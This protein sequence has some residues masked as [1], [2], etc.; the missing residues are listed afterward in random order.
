MSVIVLGIASTMWGTVI[1]DFEGG[2]MDNWVAGDANNPSVL[3]NSTT[4]A[5]LG[6]GSLAVKLGGGGY[7]CL[8]W[9]APTVPE[10][11]AGVKLQFDLTMIQSEWTQNN[12]T[13]VADKIAL[14]SN[15][16]SGYQEY[17]NLAVAKDR[18][19]GDPVPL[20][21]GPWGPDALKTYTLDISDYDL[22]DANWFQIGISIQQNPTE[23][24]GYFYIDNVKMFGV[25]MAY[26]PQ[27]ADGSKDVPIDTNISWKPGAYANKH[28]VYFGTNF[29]DVNDA[30]RTTPRG[31][32]VRP[33]QDA[34][35]YDPPGLLQSGKIYY[36]RI[37]EVNGPTTWRGDVWR[38]STPYALQGYV[39]GNWENSM[40]G[41][42]IWSRTRATSSYS[43]TGA[44][45][46]NKTLKLS[47]PQGW[48]F[49]LQL[50]LNAAQLEALKANDLFALDV[51]WVKSEWEGRS[52]SNVDT[53]A[54]NS[55]GFNWQWKQINPPISDTSNPSSPGQWNPSE[56]GDVDTRTITWDYSG[57]PVDDIPAG[58]GTQLIIATG[59]EAQT[60]T[61]GPAIYYFDNARLLNTKPALFPDPYD[62]EKDVTTDPTLSW[63]T[64]KFA[65]KHDVY[66][67]T[68]YDDVNDASR[69]NDPYGLLV[70]QDQDANTYEPGTLA[71][72]TT[73]YWRV[74]EVNDAHTDKLWKGA[75][76]R[77]TTGNYLVLDDFEDYDNSCGRVYYT[78]KDGWKFDA[79]PDCNVAAYAG[80]NTGATIGHDIWSLDSPYYNGNLVETGIIHGGNQS[81]PMY[82]D[83]SK[84][85]YYSETE[86]TWATAQD[87]TVNSI[88]AL[89]LWFRGLL[90]YV[91]SFNYDEVTDTYTI[92]ASGADIWGTRDEF[93]YVYKQL[94]GD[95]SI[96]AKIDSIT[97]TDSWAKAGVMIRDT[98]DPNSAHASVFI[99]PTNRIAF[100]WRTEKGAD[101]GSPDSTSHTVTDA[102]KLPHWIKLTRTGNVFAVQH[103]NKGINWDDI[104]PDNPEDPTSLTIQMNPNVYIGLALTAHNANLVC[105]A[106]IANVTLNGT[107]NPSGNRLTTSADIGI[108]SND[109]ES[110]YVAIEDAAGHS[111]PVLHSE[112]NA[113]QIISWQE[114]NIPLKTF[115]DAGVDLKSVKKITIGVGNKT[116][117][118]PGGTGIVYFDDIRLY[119]P[120]CVS[121]E[122]KDLTGDCMMD[123]RDIEMM[124][125]QWLDTAPPELSADLNAD[126]QVDL[127]DFAALAQ[128]W[129]TEVL[130][131]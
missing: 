46:N 113:V 42:F 55:A 123:Y 69:T 7:W 63:T 81:M 51:T 20:D 24:S 1:G 52:W 95:G 70:S 92:T 62:G 87:W 45:L 44:T 48:D 122:A 101:M 110:L 130:W 131:P 94:N 59:Q 108:V 114:W 96:I 105:E 124:A 129:L 43:T 53:I 127:K 102:F 68:N 36:W 14:N 116:S 99:T 39:V 84:Q 47:A 121:S 66:F 61:M 126:N 10:T 109:A 30:N 2:S 23:G 64:G 9:N 82:Y 97:N 98:L 120:R 90:G 80:N 86:R 60:S 4:G 33:N 21:W 17:N 100:Q 104:I 71:F 67:G 118:A 89:T 128:D 111:K 74:D 83:N 91:G 115:S 32:L 72:D 65:A 41:W 88:A 5:T 34:N 8:T 19:T 75:V 49:V 112:P 22:T 18:V 56:F 106:K 11:L 103:S 58:A 78:W 77:F 3:T 6:N 28:D 15:G 125:E 57:V 37:D 27:P 54:I 50:N 13:K 79:R 93:H 12:W 107:V 29:D 25:G 31:V 73:Y 117:T 38:F 35:T 16:A 119:R 40:D 76:W 85:P 26:G